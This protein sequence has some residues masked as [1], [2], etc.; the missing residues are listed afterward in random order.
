[1][2]S[3][4]LTIISFILHVRLRCAKTECLGNYF[5]FC[6]SKNNII[7]HFLTELTTRLHQEA[8]T[9]YLLSLFFIFHEGLQQY[10]THPLYLPYNF[11]YSPTSFCLFHLYFITIHKDTSTHSLS[12][13]PATPLPNF[14]PAPV[15]YK[16][17]IKTLQS[18]PHVL[19]HIPFPLQ[20]DQTGRAPL[21]PHCA[22]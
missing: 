17:R 3:T 9:Y 12:Q 19:M 14:L 11:R 21:A 8:S 6:F 16:R 10:T 4:A 5:F 15:L 18:S 2:Y 22:G 20:G 7:L 1:M 13:L